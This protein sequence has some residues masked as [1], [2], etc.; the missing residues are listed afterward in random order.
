MRKREENKIVMNIAIWGAGKFGS[1][2]LEQL[3]DNEAVNIVCI[4]DNHADLKEKG[5]IDIVGPNDFL[6]KYSDKTDYILVAFLDGKAIK[7][8]LLDMGI[9]LWG[10]IDNCVF[11]GHLRLL[12]DLQKDINIMWNSDKEFDLPVLETLETHVVDY[13]NLNCKGCSHF[14]NLFDKGTQIPYEIFERDIKHLS[15][16]LYI[17]IFNLLGG[18]V[19]LSERI[20]D[21]VSCIGK[22]MPKTNI[23]LVTNGILIPG[24]KQEVLECMAKYSVKF[25]ISEYLPIQKLKD[26]IVLT[27]ERY[28]IDY[29][30]REGIDT[31]GKNIDLSGENDP[32]KAQLTCRESTC[33]FLRNGKIFKCPFSALGNY[34]FNYYNIPLHFEE[35]INIF[36]EDIDWEVVAE[37]LRK[38]PIEQCKYCGPE[39]RFP[40]EIS[41]HP[42][43][44]E[45]LIHV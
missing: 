26:K 14:S 19:L 29:E 43:K 37:K 20:E 42:Q 35:G 2:I 30:F 12:K 10:V 18:E 27:L 9:E 34:Y 11:L 13:C 16:N 6:A 45:W 39:E 5:N 25:S 41:L 31:F 40:W 33:Q 22:Y 3:K 36:G 44:E 7:K 17:K 24:L 28:N 32:E 15:N 8:Q 4:I 1:Y 23:V 38:Q 21:Y